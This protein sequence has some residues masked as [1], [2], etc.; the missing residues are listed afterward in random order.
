MW[1]GSVAARSGSRQ[2]K[3]GD[4]RLI[5][6]PRTFCEAHD[7]FGGLCNIVVGSD[8][9]FSK[10]VRWQLSQGTRSLIA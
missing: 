2:H 10:G 4:G 5:G 3:N 1:E 8:V 7:R 6:R 9:Y